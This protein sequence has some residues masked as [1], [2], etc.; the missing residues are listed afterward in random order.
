MWLATRH[1]YRR[2]YFVCGLKYYV[3][4]TGYLRVIVSTSSSNVLS[5]SGHMPYF[6]MDVFESWGYD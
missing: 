1:Y 5:E 3:P 4:D 6:A 2:S